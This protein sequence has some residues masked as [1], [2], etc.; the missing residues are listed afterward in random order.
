MEFIAYITIGV[1]VGLTASVMS[2]IEE[3][4]TAFRRDTTDDIISHND[5]NLVSGWLF[6]TG[7]SCGLVLSASALTIFWGPGANGSG[8]AELMGYMNG[9]NYPNVI[10]FETFV[11]KVFGVVLAVL[12]GLC[13]GKE[14]PLAHIGGIIGATVPY[15]PIPRLE[16]YRTDNHKRNMIAAG[17]SAGV[18]AAFG[19]PIGG[20][21]FAF[22]ISKPNVFWKFSI[23]WKAC[24]SCTIAV[25]VLA[26]CQSCMKGEGIS[27]TNSAVLKFGVNN[28][29]PPTVDVIPGA[30]IVGAIS[31]VL[32][33]FFVIVNS[34]F[35]MMRKKIIKKTWM[36]LAEAAFFSIATTTVFF[37]F[38]FVFEECRTTEGVKDTD[39]IVNGAC[40][41]GQFNPLATMF[42]NTEGDAIRS[43]ISGFDEAGGV[44]ATGWH[45]FVF[46]TTWYVFT[47]STYGVWVPAG[48]FL[49]GI[50]IGC[51]IGGLYSEVQC[52]ILGNEISDSY[53]TGNGKNFAV[54]QVLIGA[55]AMLSAY[56]R[57]TFSLLVIMLETT[58]SI[59]I[60]LPMTIA[61]FVARVV[62]NMITNSLYDR[63]LRAKNM[64]FL[65][66]EAPKQT[67]DL[68]A[69]VVMSKDCVTIPTIAN[70]AACKKALESGHCG[71]PVVNTAGKLV[72]LIPKNFLVKILRKKAFYDKNNAD[73]S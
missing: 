64:C 21:L 71:F 20:T 70:M 23:I 36:K 24:I 2:N 34:N 48:L 18:S 47:I 41:E 26:I 19:A 60:F 25:F 66:S 68:L 42:Y 13:V 33:G 51:A 7:L 30:I 1:L 37:W 6:F 5:G 53:D 46:V 63:A 73:R 52:M 4:V 43:L 32:G 17:C 62:G 50:I 69:S 49:P 31:G 56:S 38:P 14:G 35:A 40:P 67:K 45:L 44:N 65:R 12:G 15:L 8:V 39:V 55:G 59:N 27:D 28:I 58:S 54:T 10:G 22:E 9:I 57:L 3:H 29:T 11:T 61:I 72:G 16:Q